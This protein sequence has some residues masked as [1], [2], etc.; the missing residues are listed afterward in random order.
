MEATLSPSGGARQRAVG[1]HAAAPV[2]AHERRR[3]VALA[4]L[5]DDA[6]GALVDHTS[7]CGQR[8]RSRASVQACSGVSSIAMDASIGAGAERATNEMKAV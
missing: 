5:D 2:E 7:A 8:A 4:N 3:M 6:P 1:E